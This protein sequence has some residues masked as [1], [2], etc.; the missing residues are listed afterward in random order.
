MPVPLRP[1]HDFDP[2]FHVFIASTKST[3]CGK[4][5]QKHIQERG[6]HC[7]DRKN[8][9]RGQTA[10]GKVAPGASPALLQTR[11]LEARGAVV[12]RSVI[13]N[14][15]GVS[16]RPRFNPY[17]AGIAAARSKCQGR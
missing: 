10:R 6:F 16:L 9:V 5:R 4:S 3:S 14:M 12:R 1:F 15:Y 17:S 11:A 7:G 8:I 2:L 13:V